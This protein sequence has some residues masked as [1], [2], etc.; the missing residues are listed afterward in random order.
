EK[1]ASDL[2]ITAGR[3]PPMKINGKLFAGSKKPLSPEQ[4]REGVLS[5][6]NKDQQESFKRGHEGNFSI[7]T[8]GLGRFPVGAFYQRNLIGMVLRRIEVNIPKVAELG[9]PEIIE[10]LAMTKRGLIIFVG[11]TGTGKST[12]LAS[13]I[14][15]RNEH[16][17]GHIVSIEDPIEYIH[18][19][20]GC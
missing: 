12:S 15:H 16:S 5:V 7:K 3:P 17:T 6:M 20:H 19:H 13:M 4:S 18:Q 14:G 9:L 8:H 11:A 1:G 2:F 10:T